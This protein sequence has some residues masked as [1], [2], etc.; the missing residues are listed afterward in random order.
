MT[1]CLLPWSFDDVSLF[2]SSFDDV[3]DDVITR[4]HDRGDL[5]SCLEY[6]LTQVWST[7]DDPF[8]DILIFLG[9]HSNLFSERCVLKP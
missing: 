6:N 3:L 7:S 2:L 4:D 8:R 9:Y 5:P 1:S